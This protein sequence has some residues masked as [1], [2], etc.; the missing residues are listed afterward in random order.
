VVNETLEKLEKTLDQAADRIE[1]LALEN[2]LLKRALADAESRMMQ[3]SVRL[4]SLADRFPGVS[5]KDAP[6]Q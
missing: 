1:S 2:S 4:R 3:A 6:R 5:T